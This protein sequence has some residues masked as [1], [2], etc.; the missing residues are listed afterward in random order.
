MSV[1]DLFVLCGVH[2][3]KSFSDCGVKPFAAMIV[4]P[5]SDW[6]L[7]QLICCVM[8]RDSEDFIRL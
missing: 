2:L 3:K 5:C 6:L 4:T 8:A 7:F 1:E